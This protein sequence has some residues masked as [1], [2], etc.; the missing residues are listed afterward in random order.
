MQDVE[1]FYD[2]RSPYTYFAW[3]RR[4]VLEAAG[5]RLIYAP[6][7]IDALLNFQ[8]GREAW[9][10][11]ADPLAPPKRRH[12]MSDIPRMARYWGIPLGGPFTFKPHAKR[13]MCLV[14][15]LKSL[16]LDQTR[17]VDFALRTLWQ[18][19]RDLADEAVFAELVTVANL[20]DFS[21]TTALAELTSNTQQAYQAGIFGV[22]SFRH[23]GQVYFGADRMDVLAS[24]L[25]QI[26]E[27]S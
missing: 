8:C 15:A 6:V 11:Y 20:A 5:A 4:D 21:E 9:A 7:A 23:K 13:A 22:P 17:F 12:L 18:E 19:T 2:L 16:G 1:F 27:S 25:Q 10:E 24:E 26:E 3:K 14:T